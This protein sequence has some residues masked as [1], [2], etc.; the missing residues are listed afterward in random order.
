MLKSTFVGV[1]VALLLA[2]TAAFGQRT[3]GS[4]GGSA[5]GSGG[6]RA[7]S[8]RAT[9]VARTATVYR[10]ATPVRAAPRVT[11]PRVTPAVWRTVTPR[12]TNTVFVPVVVGGHHDVRHHDYA[13][14]DGDAGWGADETR[15]FVL[16]LGCVVFAVALAALVGA[17]R[18]GRGRR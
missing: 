9:A 4:F 15:A 14:N 1:L 11:P 10:A 18:G 16:V 6:V 17:I 13:E 2:A 3:G 5:W 8:P 12:R 7:S